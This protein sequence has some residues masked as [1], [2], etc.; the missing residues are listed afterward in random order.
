MYSESKVT[1]QEIHIDCPSEIFILQLPSPTV[2]IM[3]NI[4]VVWT[5]TQRNN[6]WIKVLKIIRIPTI[7]YF[8]TCLTSTPIQLKIKRHLSQT[9]TVFILIKLSYGDIIGD[10]CNPKIQ[11]WKNKLSR[12]I[13]KI[14]TSERS[15]GLFF[16]TITD[17]KATFEMNMFQTA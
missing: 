9:T 7:S 2:C 15:E 13:W 10:Y 17:N 12:K 1:A 5:Q 11:G 14:L 4:V 3:Y 16:K 6:A 8:E